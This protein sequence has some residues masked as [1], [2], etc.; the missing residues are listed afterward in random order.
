MTQHDTA[1]RVTS[2][3]ISKK[4]I[5]LEA[6]DM[7]F[8]LFCQVYAAGH[9]DGR[10]QLKGR[11]PIVQLSMDG[12]KVQ[13]HQSLSIASRKIGIGKQTISKAALGECKSAGGYKWK[14]LDQFKKDEAEVCI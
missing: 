10:L 9:D 8:D 12:S 2:E 11:R 4:V 5:P 7:F 1:Y 13:V 6:R 3:L 14:Y